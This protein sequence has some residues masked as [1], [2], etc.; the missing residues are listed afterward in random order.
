M[1][2]IPSM[3]PSVGLDLEAICKPWTTSL[4]DG[5]DKRMM[6]R[7][8]ALRSLA[9]VLN[10]CLG[11]Y[12][13]VMFQQNMKIVDAEA[14]GADPL[15]QWYYDDQVVN[16]RS[17]TATVIHV[18]RTAGAGD[19]YAGRY[20]GGAV[21]E[22]TT[23]Y[24]SVPGAST[25]Y[26]N[27]METSYQVDRGAAAAA[28]ITESASTFNG[29]TMT[30][31]SVQDDELSDLVSSLHD[32]VV[33][34]LAKKGYEVL[35]DLLEE[36]RAKLHLLE[37]YNLSKLINWS[38]Q[39]LAAGWQTVSAGTSDASGMATISASY[40]N[41]IDQV[42][43]T[44]SATSP[45]WSCHVR[46]RGWG[47]QDETNGTY[48]KA[49]CRVHAVCAGAGGLHGK[50]RFEGPLDSCEIEITNGAAQQWWGGASD[51]IHLDSTKADTD[52]TAARNKIDVLFKIDG[53]VTAE[54]VTIYGLGA[55]QDA[56]PY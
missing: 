9:Q 18:P 52:A 1:T 46:N 48:V 6:N 20:T 39:R 36:I 26:A 30:G 28:E 42:T 15:Y 22:K 19:W 27:I 10:H 47:A 4:N 14:V 49:M 55:W 38:A 23:V 21:T 45:G 29:F 37:R 41:V 53:A 13:R 34:E 44:R 25:P 17:S 11:R 40:V 7:A 35:D 51:Y 56:P 24:T 8:A 16:G 12:P 50:V 33:P 3:Y 5:T 31:I 2:Q 43:A 32:Y 54:K